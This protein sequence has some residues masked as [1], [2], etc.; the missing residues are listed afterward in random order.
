MYVRILCV[1]VCI[2]M[3]VCMY[4]KMYALIG[5]LLGFWNYSYETIFS[6]GR[7]VH[8]L[9]KSVM[10]VCLLGVC[11]QWGLGFLL[12]A[13][14]RGKLQETATATASANKEKFDIHIG[15]IR[16]FCIYIHTYIHAYIHTY[17]HT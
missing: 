8:L 9:T 5:N 13:I 16:C 1:Y 17:L 7:F 4:E 6:H 15:Y 12:G 3:Y 14:I 10:F 11:M 2:T